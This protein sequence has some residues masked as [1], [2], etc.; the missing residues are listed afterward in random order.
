MDKI[1]SRL[2]GAA[3]GLALASMPAPVVYPSEPTTEK[4]DTMLTTDLDPE[5]IQYM[6][7]VE[8]GTKTGFKD[9]LWFPHRSVEDLSGTIAYGHKIQPGENY[10]HG[11]S[12]GTARNLLIQDLRKAEKRASEMLGELKWG[13]LESWEREILI[14]YQFTGVLESF[15]KFMHAVIYADRR[16]MR[17][18][19]KRYAT[20]NGTRREL[21]ERNRLFYDRYLKQF[22]R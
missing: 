22:E 6:M 20:I 16:T 5:F 17:R 2:L 9:D 15:P 12:E 4:Y 19:Y 11:I 1:R 18:E 21:K 14:D 10:S 13:R 7:T 3:L 8:N